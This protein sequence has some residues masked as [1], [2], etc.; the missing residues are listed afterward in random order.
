[1]KVASLFREAVVMVMTVTVKS[2]GIGVFV[3]E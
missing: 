1:M 2:E 3:T